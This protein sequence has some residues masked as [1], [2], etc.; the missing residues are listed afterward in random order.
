MRH[1][2]IYFIVFILLF[3]GCDKKS[4]E[5]KDLPTTVTDIDGNIYRTVKIGDQWW[6]AKNLEVTHY[7]NGDVIPEISDSLEWI[8]TSNGACCNYDNDESYTATYGR[9]YNWYAVNDDRDIAP[10]GWHVPSDA[11]WK[12]LEMYLGMSQSDA[13]ATGY[14]GTNEGSKLKESGT[15]HWTMFNTDATNESGFTALPGGHIDF[16]AG[17]YGIERYGYWWSDSESDSTRYWW[18]SDSTEAWSRVLSFN[19]PTVKRGSITK[20]FG[21]SVRCLKD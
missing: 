3:I 8:N 5:P 6:M 12:Q 2:S 1:T 21:L 4:T 19:D 20:L 15:I 17:F 11:E 10:V 13:D 16:F 18:S 9:L 14:R 7:S